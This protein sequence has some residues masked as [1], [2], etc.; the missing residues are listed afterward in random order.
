MLQAGAAEVELRLAA[1]EAARVSYS[2]AGVAAIVESNSSTVLASSG[3][4]RSSTELE[5]SIGR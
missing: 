4:S 2:A 3:D 1:G 5:L